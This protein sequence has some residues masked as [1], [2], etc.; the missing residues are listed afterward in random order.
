[1]RVAA[2]VAWNVMKAPSDETLARY[3]LGTADEEEAALVERY[4]ESDSSG[5]V[6][7]NGCAPMTSC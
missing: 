1:M 3:V 2:A 5:Y 7:L 6:R 4:L